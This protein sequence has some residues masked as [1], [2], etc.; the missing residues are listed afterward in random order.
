LFTVVQKENQQYG[1]NT[2]EHAKH[3]ESITPPPPFSNIPAYPTQ[4]QSGIQTTEMYTGS[5]R[6]GFTSVIVCDQCQ[7]C[8]DIEGLTDAHYDPGND[9]LFKGRNQSCPNSG[10]RPD[11]YAENN[12]DLPAV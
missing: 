4:C 6:P 12:D 1:V 10:Q 5:Q 3:M 11:G 8:R 9:H 7:S 2:P